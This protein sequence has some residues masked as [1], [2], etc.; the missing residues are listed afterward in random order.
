MAEEK[1]VEQKDN[2]KVGDK[3][4][5]K[6]TK[7]LPAPVDENIRTLETELIIEEV[8]PTYVTMSYK[9][10]KEFAEEHEGVA[11]TKVSFLRKN[12]KEFFKKAP[13]K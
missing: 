5:I 8:H 3:L 13:K 11:S 12:V 9:T 2:L 1:K 10:T 7:N 4:L 6:S